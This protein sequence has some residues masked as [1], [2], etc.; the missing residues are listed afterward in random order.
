M[1]GVQPSCQTPV[2]AG[3]LG[4][5]AA[6]P[7]FPGIGRGGGEVGQDR[8][9]PQHGL[10]PSRSRAA[11]RAPIKQLVCQGT[12]PGLAP[13]LLQRH[14]FVPS[15]WSSSLLASH[16]GLCGSPYWALLVVLVLL[17]AEWHHR[18]HRVPAAGIAASWDPP[19]H[20]Q[21]FPASGKL[22]LHPSVTVLLLCELALPWP[23]CNPTELVSLPVGH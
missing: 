20:Q 12:A 3:P 23:G 4:W 5:Q 9:N 7:A 8:L 11:P 19:G 2:P 6:P 15:Y 16:P 17:C 22:Q 10:E 21:Q 14:V 18:S 1:P 13:E